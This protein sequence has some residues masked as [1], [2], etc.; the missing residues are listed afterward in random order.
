MNTSI[1]VTR[2]DTIA[3]AGCELKNHDHFA[4]LSRGHRQWNEWIKSHPEIEV[5]F[6]GCE[7]DSK[8]I[9]SLSFAH[10]HFPD[11]TRFINARFS[12]DIS[13]KNARFGRNCSFSG[14]T[15]DATVTFN[16]ARFLANANFSA[17]R[18]NADTSFVST[19]FGKYS[20]FSE[21]SFYSEAVFQGALFKDQANFD[22]VTFRADAS[23][24][25]V[26]FVRRSTFVRAQ[27]FAFT[28]FTDTHFSGVA[29]FTHVLFVI[30]PSFRGVQGL[31]Y[32]DIH[33]VD[34]RLGTR[35]RAWRRALLGE[36]SNDERMVPRLRML[37]GIAALTHFRDGERDLFLLER[38]CE[39]G[40][41]WTNMKRALL[42][43]LRDESTLM[44][45]IS[46]LGSA[47]AITMRLFTESVLMLLYRWSSNCGRSS[48]LPVLW[49]MVMSPVFQ[50]IYRV[51]YASMQNTTPSSLDEQTLKLLRDY[52]Q[53]SLIPFAS[54]TRPY[55]QTAVERLF[56]D[57]GG[58]DIPTVFQYLA[59]AQGVIDL[60]LIFLISVALRNFFHMR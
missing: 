23:F 26:H 5:D 18:F 16:G 32:C 33:D 41:K 37:R 21:A 9:E 59:I 30:P 60:V 13:F 42:G 4:L 44:S 8:T 38:Q 45:R 31:E 14:A 39:L 15:F 20:D 19:R 11:N 17:V 43:Q 2:Q 7:F 1:L 52:A 25:S 54:T 27:F 56:A 47:A 58:L 24:D 55:Y 6:S 10:C 29:R 51:I 28:D 48:L 3:P 53:G 46:G 49:L 34:V 57:D 40:C 50:W 12:S 22:D 35:Q 36:W